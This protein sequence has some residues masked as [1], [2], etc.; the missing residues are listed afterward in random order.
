M[1]RG[2]RHVIITPCLLFEYMDIL[3]WLVLNVFLFV[4][5]LVVVA[6]TL[7]C[8]TLTNSQ[9]AAGGMA[10]G[11]IVLGFILGVIPKPGHISTR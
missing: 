7:F 8:S 10:V 4:Y 11:I 1:L 2:N 3:R 5:A 6:I 9:A